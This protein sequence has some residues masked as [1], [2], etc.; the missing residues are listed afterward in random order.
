MGIK[1]YSI[2]TDRDDVVIRW[3]ER[4]DGDWVRWE[5]A[6]RLERER[7]HLAECMRRA[8]LESFMRGR[9]P[10]EVG[11][12]LRDVIG[13]YYQAAKQAER[14]RDEAQSDLAHAEEVVDRIKAERDE[15]VSALL[16]T[17][18]YIAAAGC[19]CLVD[20]GSVLTCRDRSDDREDW[21][22]ACAAADALE[23]NDAK[24]GGE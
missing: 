10:A 9:T 7:D 16:S 5:D 6:G 15:S 1:R 20:E 12:H 8:S 13:S 19:G 24:G 14:E 11:D 2:G 23:R 21:C 22:L 3:R 18:R 17:L 4:Q